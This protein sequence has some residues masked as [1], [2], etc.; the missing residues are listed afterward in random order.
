MNLSKTY[1]TTPLLTLLLVAFG[2]QL[3]A[4][5]TT[6]TKDIKISTEDLKTYVGEYLYDNKSEQGFDITVSIEGDVKLMAQPT[7]KSQPLTTLVAISE[8]R[9]ELTDTGGLQITF[10]RNDKKEI[11]SLIISNDG[12]SFTCL[13]KKE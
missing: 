6:S 9:F 3:F 12:S 4:Q 8:D 13:R 5:E 11:I 10:N 7:N 2:S 1:L